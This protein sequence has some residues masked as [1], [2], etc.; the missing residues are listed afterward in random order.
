[1]GG[2]PCQTSCKYKH[3]FPTLAKGFSRCL[4]SGVQFSGAEG[5]AGAPLVVDGGIDT[6]GVEG[7]NSASRANSGENKTGVG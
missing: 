5:L 7:G 6:A 4:A 3:K 2:R 1:M